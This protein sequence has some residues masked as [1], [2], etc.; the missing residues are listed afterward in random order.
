MSTD[1]KN[2]QPKP[3]AA[4]APEAP[5]PK[6]VVVINPEPRIFD[7]PY[8][9]DEPK[10]AIKD[11]KGNELV[12]PRE[13]EHAFVLPGI[14]FVSADVLARAGVSDHPTLEIDADL[15]RLPLA[16]AKKLAAESSSAPALRRWLEIERPLV[17]N[18]LTGKAHADVC[19]AIEKRLKDRRVREAA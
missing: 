19:D 15:A 17:G 12:V 4:P 10:A 7:L 8:Y 18:T 1:N 14:N 2:A 6:D 13:V 11:G 5:A 3:P 9:S 16:K